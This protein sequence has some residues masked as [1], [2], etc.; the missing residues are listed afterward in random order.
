MNSRQDLS[1]PC[2]TPSPIT[3]RRGRQG[4]VGRGGLSLRHEKRQ[5]HY[6]GPGADPALWVDLLQ[7]P[8][9]QYLCLRRRGLCQSSSGVEDD[10]CLYCEN[11][12][13][14]G[15]KTMTEEPS[16]L[17]RMRLYEKVD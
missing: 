9:Q 3:R 14:C 6:H 2:S 8:T 17:L 11:Q 5:F 7:Q 1:E 4:S 15:C 16:S 12:V 13:A 10:Q